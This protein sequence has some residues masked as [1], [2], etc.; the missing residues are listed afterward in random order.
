MNFILTKKL[1]YK[2]RMFIWIKISDTPK[3]YWSVLHD[4][5]SQL[6]WEYQPPHQKQ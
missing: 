6:W 3:T 4:T 5:D 1:P 2:V